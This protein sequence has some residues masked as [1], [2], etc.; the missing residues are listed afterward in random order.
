M[1]SENDESSVI[2]NIHEASMK[3][4]FYWTPEG[5]ANA[6]L[7]AAAPEMCELVKKVAELPV[8]DCLTAPMIFE[9][10]SLLDHI[11]GK[12]GITAHEGTE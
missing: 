2:A 11:D 12:E 4:C 10:R 9:A 6:R 1:Y 5:V 7:I 8:I 3:S